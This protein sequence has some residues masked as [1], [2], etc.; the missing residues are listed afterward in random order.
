MKFE[1]H[2]IILLTFIL[3]S[4]QSDKNSSDVIAKWVWVKF[5]A[6]MNMEFIKSEKL[7]E[8]RWGFELKEN[9]NAVYMYKDPSSSACGH[10][11]FLPSFIP[12]EAKWYWE[13]D[14]VIC[15]KYTYNETLEN[16]CY[17]IINKQDDQMTL[18]EIE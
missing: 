18:F 15:F 11:L 9:G 1:K 4:F 2:L 8:H 7:D 10:P 12:T 6:D 3:F 17:K 14:S 5:T 13:K 16:T